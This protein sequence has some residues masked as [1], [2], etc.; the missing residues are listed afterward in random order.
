MFGGSS[1]ASHGPTRPP[2]GTSWEVSSGWGGGFVR[3]P[4]PPAPRQE[5]SKSSAISPYRFRLSACAFG[6]SRAVAELRGSATDYFRSL[7]PPTKIYTELQIGRMRPQDETIRPACDDVVTKET[8]H[9]GARTARP[10]QHRFGRG[11]WGV[12]AWVTTATSNIMQQLSAAHT[13]E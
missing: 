5:A 9:G 11:V 6:C 7:S 8:L 10:G 2:R 4:G 13:C 12:V 3:P 1:E